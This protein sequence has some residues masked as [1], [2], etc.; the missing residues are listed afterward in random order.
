MVEIV[1]IITIIQ[2]G[3][4]C[5]DNNNNKNTAEIVMIITIIQ[6]GRDCNDNNNNTIW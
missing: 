4:D 3:R 1:M 6:Y 2:Y 5:N